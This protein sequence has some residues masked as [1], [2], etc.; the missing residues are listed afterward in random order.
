M[1]EIITNIGLLSM[2]LTMSA[3]ADIR[4]IQSKIIGNGFRTIGNTI[5]IISPKIELDGQTYDLHTGSITAASACALLG[6]S[7]V[8][9]DQGLSV[10][11]SKRVRIS[12]TG[13]IEFIEGA[14]F[15]SVLSCS[16]QN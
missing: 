2:I 1:K 8:S 14:R 15:L 4:V 10:R 5:S 12:E 16:K 6:G 7:L 3:H 9:Y 13:A 11:S